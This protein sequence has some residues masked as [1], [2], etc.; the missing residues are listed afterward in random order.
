MAEPVKLDAKRLVL[1]LAASATVLNLLDV[2]TTWLGLSLG[3][4]EANPFAVMLQRGGAGFAEFLVIKMA[5]S[6][7]ILLAGMIFVK[8]EHSRRLHDLVA[9][10]FFVMALYFGWTVVGNVLLMIIR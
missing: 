9:L 4:K 5:Y 1:V 6:T 3:L 2:L 10:T 8:Q 7:V